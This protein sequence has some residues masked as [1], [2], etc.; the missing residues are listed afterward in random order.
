M[1]R[2]GTANPFSPVQIRVSPDQI[3]KRYETYFCSADRAHQISSHQKQRKGALD[4]CLIRNSRVG[5]SK[6]VSIEES[7]IYS[8]GRG[9]GKTSG[10]ASTTIVNGKKFLGAT[11]NQEYTASPL[12]HF[13]QRSLKRGTHLIK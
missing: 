12:F 3:N 2:R 9:I 4:T 13:S 7:R 11:P 10:C 5:F 8:K 6:R 1:V